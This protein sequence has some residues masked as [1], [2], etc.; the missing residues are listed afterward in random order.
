M[1]SVLLRRWRVP[2]CVA[3]VVTIVALLAGCFGDGTFLVGSGKTQVAPGLYTT[4]VAPG[5]FC[6]W[7]RLRSTSGTPDAVITN[8]IVS[9]GR[10][11]LLVARSDRAV[12]SDGCGVWV[13]ASAKSYNPTPTRMVDG[14]YRVNVDVRAGTYL[15]S[16]GSR[17]YWERRSSWDTS[18]SNHIL[19][20]HYGP[21]QQIVTIARSDVG[22]GTSGCGSWTKIG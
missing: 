22:F 7:A 4:S 16:G 21:G 8:D 14:E 13:P 10:A 19:V 2:T 15:A 3:G 20:N 11:F 1:R 9:G 6:Y 17:C 5:G 18:N 12:E